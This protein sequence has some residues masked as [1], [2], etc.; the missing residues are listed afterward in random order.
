MIKTTKDRIEK[1]NVFVQ[2]LQCLTPLNFQ[3]TYVTSVGPMTPKP[4]DFRALDVE[5]SL[6]A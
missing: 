5:T 3:S 1:C 2:A 4:S 6:R